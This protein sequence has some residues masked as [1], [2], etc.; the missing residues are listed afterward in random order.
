MDSPHL[1]LPF[2]HALSLAEAATV[3]LQQAACISSL[4]G[5]LELPMQLNS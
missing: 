5:S 1:V 4:L 2:S 3:L